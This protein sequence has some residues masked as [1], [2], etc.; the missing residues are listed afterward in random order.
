MNRDV[1]NILV[2]EGYTNVYTKDPP[3]DISNYILVSDSGG[4][5]LSG[6]DAGFGRPTIQIIVAH[7][8]DE[9]LDTNIKAIINTL[10]TEGSTGDIQGFDLLSDTIDLGRDENLRYL[11]SVNFIVFYNYN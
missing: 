8:N 9:T 10:I 5:G 3:K 7:K 11:K 4:F 1:A 2:T 6:E